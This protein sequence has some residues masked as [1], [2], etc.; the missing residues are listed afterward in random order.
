[1]RGNASRHQ[2]HQQL[3]TNEPFPGI[4][5]EIK[6]TFKQPNSE[7]RNRFPHSVV[8]W[9]VDGVLVSELSS[10]RNLGQ[11]FRHLRQVHTG[12]GINGS[13]NYVESLRSA[14]I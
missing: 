13:G 7:F 2:A 10:A 9:D 8:D 1:M 5:K 11:Y 12:F 4:Q 14:T 6:L 3:G